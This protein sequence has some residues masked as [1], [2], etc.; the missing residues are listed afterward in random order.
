LQVVAKVSTALNHLRLRVDEGQGKLDRFEVGRPRRNVV[1][2]NRVGIRFRKS[3]HSEAANFNR[4]GRQVWRQALHLQLLQGVCRPF[5]QA[6]G[7]RALIFFYLIIWRVSIKAYFKSVPVL[8]WLVDIFSDRSG[9]LVL[10]P[11]QPWLVHRR[12]KTGTLPQRKVCSARRGQPVRRQ[13]WPHG[14]ARQE[15]FAASSTVKVVGIDGVGIKWNLDASSWKK[16]AGEWN[17][18]SKD[19]IKSRTHSAIDWPPL[20]P[21]VSSLN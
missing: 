16:E 17:S 10:G 4:A 8:K 19:F 15:S 5:G 18:F 12:S 1:F 7:K 9:S 11:F 6:S 13:R 21:F 2:R 20:K 3:F 14:G